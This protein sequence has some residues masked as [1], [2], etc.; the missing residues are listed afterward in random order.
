MEPVCIID[1][2]N[3]IIGVIKPNNRKNIIIQANNYTENY[4]PLY[5]T[6][7]TANIN[8]LVCWY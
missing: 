5:L 3:P 1:R 8:E 6:R 4:A 7:H 2:N